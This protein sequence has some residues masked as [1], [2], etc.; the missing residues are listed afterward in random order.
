MR[1]GFVVS[2]LAVTEAALTCAAVASADADFFDGHFPGD[3]VLPAVAQLSG[4][5]EPVAQRAWPSLG[6]LVAASQLK[7]HRVCRPGEALAL[8]CA[9]EGLTVRFTLHVGNAL[10]SAGT[11]S[12]GGAS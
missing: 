5:V 3:P 7:F 11:L 6:A 10:A 9:R 12:F 2:E 4:L 8:R 1:E